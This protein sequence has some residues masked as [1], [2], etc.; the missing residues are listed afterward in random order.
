[1]TNLEK[2]IKDH[3][4]NRERMLKD[5]EKKIKDVKKNMQSASKDLKVCL[6]YNIMYS[7]YLGG[8]YSH[9]DI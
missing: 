7:F 2:S 1:M 4:S 8:E 9:L 6:L 5:L 3:S